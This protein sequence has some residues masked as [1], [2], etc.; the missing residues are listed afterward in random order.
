MREVGS[1]LRTRLT[2]SRTVV[3]VMVTDV[4]LTAVATGVPG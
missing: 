1:V 3:L 2:I 4:L